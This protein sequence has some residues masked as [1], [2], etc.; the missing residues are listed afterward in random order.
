MPARPP[1]RRRSAHRGCFGFRNFPDHVDEIHGD[2]FDQPLAVRDVRAVG[3]S[4]VGDDA[5]ERRANLERGAA[6]LAMLGLTGLLVLLNAS[7]GGLEL[8]QGQR[9]LRLRFL[10]SF[11]GDRAGVEQSLHTRQILTS[12][13]ELHARLVGGQLE[14]GQVRRRAG[15]GNDGRDHLAALDVRSD[16]GQPHGCRQTAA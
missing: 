5:R 4:H 12:V 16:H 15:G 14:R 2:D 10:N 1:R 7:L 9:F 11:R 3:H 13:I 6:V 8:S